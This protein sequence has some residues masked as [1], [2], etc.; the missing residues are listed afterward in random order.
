MWCEGHQK[1]IPQLRREDGPT[2]GECISSRT[3]GSRGDHPIR[4]I[5]YQLTSIPRGNQPYGSKQLPTRHDGLI[6][7]IPVSQRLTRPDVFGVQHHAT[8][9]PCVAVEEFIK[10]LGPFLALNLNEEAYPAEI[11]T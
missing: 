5:T 11:H 9:N 10:V 1:Y 6:Q 7:S 3:S 2:C 8:L 4:K